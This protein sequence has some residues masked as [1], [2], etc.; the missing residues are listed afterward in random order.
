MVR[1]A[2]QGKTFMMGDS[3]VVFDKPVHLV[4]LSA[5]FWM[6][7]TEVTQG[8][9]N[10]LMKATFIGY[11]QPSWN[12]PYGV[13]NNY[14]AYY[15]SWFDA[16]LYCN[17][18]TKAM[19]SRDTVYSYTGIKGTPGNGCSELA[20][21]NIDL[22]K[23]GYRLPTEAQWE[24]SCRGGTTTSYYWGKNY[25][26][27][28]SSVAD[29]NEIDKYAVWVGN[30][31]NKRSGSPAYGTHMV[32]TK[33]KNAFELYDMSGNVCEWCNDWLGNYSS[34]LQTDPTGPLSGSS[35]ILRG[36]SWY[37]L[38]VHLQS[39]LRDYT[40]P[41]GAASLIGFRVCLPAQ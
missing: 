12:S 35:R 9:Y 24:Y 27:Y 32:A 37:R 36:G 26:P 4:M 34:D 16:V 38:A 33:V 13:G 21:L 7:T 28:P 14:P 30:S 18:R 3:V 39:A 10:S 31:Y 5:D 2:A 25:D 41:D 17:A 8:S 29:S 23:G 40:A 19:G 22:S 20:E 15:V 11:T 6:D 1:I